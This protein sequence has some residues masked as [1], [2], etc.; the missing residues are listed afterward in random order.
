MLASVGDEHLGDVDGAEARPASGQEA[1]VVSFAAADVEPVEPADVRQHMKK[2]RCVEMV[3]VDV[4]T[5]P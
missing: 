2:G 5:G 3:P 1:R 4:I